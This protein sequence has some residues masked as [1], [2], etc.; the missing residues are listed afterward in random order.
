VHPIHTVFPNSDAQST[1]SLP[2]HQATT[3]SGYVPSHCSHTSVASDDLGSDS[4][5][6]DSRGETQFGSPGSLKDGSDDGEEMV[7]ITVREPKAKCRT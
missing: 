5:F 2:S 1:H 7:W 3:H 6:L 4:L